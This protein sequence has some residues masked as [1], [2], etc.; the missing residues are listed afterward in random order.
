M[1]KS[2]PIL[3]LVISLI[4]LVNPCSEGEDSCSD[5]IEEIQ[6]EHHDETYF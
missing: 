6:S 4:A 3:L 1:M 2:I 5:I